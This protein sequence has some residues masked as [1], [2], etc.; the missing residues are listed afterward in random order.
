MKEKKKSVYGTK[1]EVRW[2]KREKGSESEKKRYSRTYRWKI[3]TKK[4][5]WNVLKY[6]F[7]GKGRKS[8]T[9]KLKLNRNIKTREREMNEKER[10]EINPEQRIWK[11]LWEKV[12]IKREAEK[13]RNE[14][15][16][17]CKI[18]TSNRVVKRREGE[19]GEINAG[20]KSERIIRG[21]KVE[22]ANWNESRARNVKNRGR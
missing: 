14:A 5:Q 2:M 3:E 7:Q 17:E 21:R 4:Q 9:H 13:G 19:R 15:G 12:I 10:E 6:N 18:E 8:Y 11:N 22:R 1:W 16:T 20:Q